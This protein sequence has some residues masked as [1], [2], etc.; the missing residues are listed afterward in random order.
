MTP[1]LALSQS[2]KK[3][4]KNNYNEIR[5]EPLGP[6]RSYAIFADLSR[7]LDKNCATLE[8]K[9]RDMDCSEVSNKTVTPTAA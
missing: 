7:E 9:G 3:R 6:L 2:L 1:S 4:Q 8:K 5:V